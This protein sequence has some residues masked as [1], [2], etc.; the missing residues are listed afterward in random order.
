M[1]IRRARA[2][3]NVLEKMGIFIRDHEKIVGYQTSDPNGIFHPIDQNWKSVRRLVNSE[4]GSSLLDEAG[5]RSW[6]ISASTG[7]ASR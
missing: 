4:S 6:M 3:A 5:K 7:R 2:L 1:V